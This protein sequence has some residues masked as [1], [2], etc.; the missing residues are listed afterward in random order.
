[1]LIRGLAF[2]ISSF[3]MC[4]VW[5]CSVMS[6]SLWPHGLWPARPLCPQSFPGKDPGVGCHL[7]LQGIF[8]TQGSNP[9]LLCLLHQQEDPLPPCNLRSPL[10][11]A[12]GELIDLSTKGYLNRCMTPAK[13]LKKPLITHSEENEL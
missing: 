1:M 10:L 3:F 11:C 12:A 13:I 7:L 6:D 8:P 5:V 2:Q 9:C 4:C